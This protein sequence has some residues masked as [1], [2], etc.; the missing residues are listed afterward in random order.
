[1][2]GVVTARAIRNDSESNHPGQAE[3]KNLLGP[4]GSRCNGMTPN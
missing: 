4:L 1:M 3:T 2:W